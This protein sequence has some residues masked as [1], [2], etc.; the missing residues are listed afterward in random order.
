M[1]QIGQVVTATVYDIRDTFVLL[2]TEGGRIVVQVPEIFWR[3]TPKKLHEL[4]AVGENRCV[5]IIRYDIDHDCFVG[6][7]RRVETS[8]P[9]LPYREAEESDRFAAKV[10]WRHQHTR[11]GDSLRVELSNGA[12]AMAIVPIDSAYKQGD[13]I[14]VR[15]LAVDPEEGEMYVAVD[16]L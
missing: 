11:S 3:P 10:L 14:K 4:F 15:I 7:F 1:L 9:Y 6:S 8:N 12:H 13:E 2:S 16:V 5:K